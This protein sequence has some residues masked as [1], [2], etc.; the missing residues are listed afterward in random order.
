MIFECNM[1]FSS[2]RRPESFVFYTKRV[3]YAD[4]DQDPSEQHVEESV[5]DSLRQESRLAS[6]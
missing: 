1:A 6:Q 3:K 5:E 2:W 4:N